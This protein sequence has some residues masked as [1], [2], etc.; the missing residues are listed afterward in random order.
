MPAGGFPLSRRSMRTRRGMSAYFRNFCRT[1]RSSPEDGICPSA[2]TRGERGTSMKKSFKGKKERKKENSSRHSRKPSFADLDRI[3]KRG[4]AFA[5]YF[6]NHFCLGSVLLFIILFSISFYISRSFFSLSG[7]VSRIR[8]GIKGQQ[9]QS[10]TRKARDRTCLSRFAR[11]DSYRFAPRLRDS[12]RA[13]SHEG[14]NP[15]F[16]SFTLPITLIYPTSY[17]RV[18][19]TCMYVIGCYSRDGEKSIHLHVYVSVSRE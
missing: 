3:I 8:R 2:K 15:T 10:V 13:L 19:R 4:T 14:N 16:G 9:R 17:E 11:R 7:R 12:S 18:V 5:C 6:S 1:K